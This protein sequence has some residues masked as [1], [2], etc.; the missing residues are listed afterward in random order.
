LSKLIRTAAVLATFAALALTLSAC[1]TVKPGSQQ[2]SQ[3]GGIGNVDVD[4]QLCSAE[5][6]PGAPSECELDDYTG[7]AQVIL[8]FI[9]PRG[10]TNVPA[11]F[12]AIP[13]PAPGGAPIDFRRNQSI[14]AFFNSLEGIP[15]GLEAIGYLSDVVSE[16]ENDSFEWSVKFPFGLPGAADGGSFV[17]PLKYFLAFGWRKV[18][19]GLSPDRPVE[20]ESA[21]P[22]ENAACTSTG[23]VEFGVSD[24]KVTP[25]AETTV[26]AGA[27]AEFP[28]A[29]DFGS[30]AAAPPSSFALSATTTLPGATATPSELTFPIGPLSSSKR[31]AGQRTAVVVVPPKAK[32][33]VYEVR[34]NATTATGGSTRAVAQLRVRQARV[35][36]SAKLNKSRGTATLT[37]KVPAAGTLTVSGRGIVKAQRKPNAARTVKVTVR[38]KGK[39]KKRLLANGKVRVTAKVTF[40]PTGAAAVT[41]SRPL[42]LKLTQ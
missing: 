23:E 22:D 41:V 42:N 2:T 15:A 31:F 32:E 20:C 16:N 30:S 4:F 8:A 21:A 36:I 11:S 17:G 12:T 9:V 40:Q 7:T 34:L 27:T 3:P 28:F 19:P 6:G 10:V 35:G 29:F 1:I 38:T 24:L 13:G 5:E 37:L 39:A 33:G 18:G 25:P 14:D 26:F